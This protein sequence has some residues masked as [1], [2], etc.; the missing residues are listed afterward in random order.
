VPPTMVSASDIVHGKPHPEPYLKA[1]A[2]L[3]F[4]PHD[5][6]VIEDSPAGIQSG[7][8]AGMRVIAVPTT[9]PVEELR[10][11]N[12]LLK[13]LSDLRVTTVNIP[14]RQAIHLELLVPGK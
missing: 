13:R 11:A 7:K 4:E 9:Y 14:G 6:M 12:V 5:C 2:A 3:R 10:A 8:A 1:A